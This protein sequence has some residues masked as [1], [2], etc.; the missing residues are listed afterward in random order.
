MLFIYK[1][2]C[3]CFRFEII[4]YNRWEVKILRKETSGV[5]QKYIMWNKSRH[6]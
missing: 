2:R 6:I 3:A 1:I 5:D 4:F